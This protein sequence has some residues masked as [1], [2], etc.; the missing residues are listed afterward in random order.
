M[1]VLLLLAMLNA[2][3]FFYAEGRAVQRIELA[4]IAFDLQN[5]HEWC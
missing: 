5:C 2:W 4:L 1:P 3:I